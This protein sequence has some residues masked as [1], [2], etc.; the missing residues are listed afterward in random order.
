DVHQGEPVHHRAV[1]GDDEIGGPPLDLPDEREAATARASPGVEHTHV[2]RAVTYEGKTPRREMGHDDLTRDAGGLR[3]AL[4]VHDLDD[5]VLR[6]DEHAAGRTFVRD[7][8]RVAAAVA[9]R[10]PAAE[11][12][13]D[14][15]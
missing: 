13:G 10:H 3:L 14:Q 12:A 15:L 5:D 11:C 7:E 8:A 9:V 1:A 6:C 2:A 4:A